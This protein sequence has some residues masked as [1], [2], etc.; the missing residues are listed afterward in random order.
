[1][2][3][4]YFRVRLPYLIGWGSVLLGGVSA[5]GIGNKSDNEVLIIG[6]ALAAVVG[7][8]LLICYFFIALVIAGVAALAISLL[9]GS[10]FKALL[11]FLWACVGPAVVLGLFA[12]VVASAIKYGP[13]LHELIQRIRAV[14]D[15]QEAVTR[16]GM[17]ASAP[18][19]AAR[20]TQRIRCDRICPGCGRLSPATGVV[21]DDP[22]CEE[23]QANR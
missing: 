5:C 7:G 6:G 9:A 18:T 16:S 2:I 3:R 17:S 8:V 11:S 21:C 10:F 4:E 15:S 1:M 22:D 13:R 20:I 14:G 12:A 19:P 23:P